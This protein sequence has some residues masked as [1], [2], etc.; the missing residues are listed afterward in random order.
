MKAYD[1]DL[2]DQNGRSHRL[3]DYQGKWLVLYFYP[4]DF[5]SGCT[6]QACSYRDFISEIRAK[7]A[8]VVG[9]SKDSVESHKKFYAEYH[10]NFDILSDEKAGLIKAYGLFVGVG[11]LGVA[12]RTTY[13][14]DPAGEIQKVYENVDPTKDARNILQDL[15]TMAGQ[16]G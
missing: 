15:E 10:L 2:P 3:S 14:I 13:L 9:V 7:G 16:K 6:A 11:N 12:K 4:K 1:F 8:E 5:T